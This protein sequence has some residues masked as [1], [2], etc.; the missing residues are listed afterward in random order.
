MELP[1]QN[2]LEWARCLYS[3]RSG[4]KLVF[5]SMSWSGWAKRGFTSFRHKPRATCNQ[6]RQTPS[7]WASPLYI[8]EPRLFWLYQT[9]PGVVQTSAEVRIL[10]VKASKTQVWI[11]MSVNTSVLAPLEGRWWAGA[12]LS[13]AY[14]WKVKWVWSRVSHNFDVISRTLTNTC[15]HLVINLTSPM[16][17]YAI[18][19]SWASS[20]CAA[21][22]ATGSPRPGSPPRKAQERGANGSMRGVVCPQCSKQQLNSK[23]VCLLSVN[24]S[25][26]V[27]FC[28]RVC[29]FAFRN[30]WHQKV[31]L[32][33]HVRWMVSQLHYRDVRDPPPHT[34]LREFLGPV[35]LPWS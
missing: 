21:L 20:H 30:M 3:A 18:Q 14:F 23:F 29:S 4:V 27:V 22:C 12:S 28:T 33:W 17:S 31:V 35:K 5:L 32:K 26:R 11:Y 34:T 13:I 10:D 19:V 16:L 6:Q 7:A 24:W 1:V 8:L 25:D 15:V 2:V 9:E